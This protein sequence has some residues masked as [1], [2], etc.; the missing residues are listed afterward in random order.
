MITCW[1]AYFK[2]SPAM[3]ANKGAT[4]QDVLGSVN[5]LEAIAV[6]IDQ[7]IFAINMDNRLIKKGPEF[8][9]I[10]TYD[11]ELT[12]MVPIYSKN[13]T[14]VTLGFEEADSSIRRFII[15]D[16]NDASYTIHEVG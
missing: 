14:E 3:Y 6:F 2:T 12:D 16:T 15:I 13:G 5:D 7:N 11:Y 10:L 1:K 9:D 4:W 8:I